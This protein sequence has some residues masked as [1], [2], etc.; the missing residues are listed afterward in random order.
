MK[1]FKYAI[2]MLV[3]KIRAV[4]YQILDKAHIRYY[5]TI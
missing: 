2:V 1:P 3:L 5:L 4:L